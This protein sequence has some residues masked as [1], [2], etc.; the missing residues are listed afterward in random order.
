MRHLAILCVRNEAAFL[1]EW[2]AHHRAIGFDDF[3]VFSNDCQDGT[4]AMLD[5]LEAMGHLTH[6]RNDGPYDKGGIQFT[7]LKA[8]ARHDAVKRADWILP[9]DV[10]EFVNIHTGDH[11]L[12]ALHTALPEATA[13]TLTW[14]LFG[15]AGQVRFQDTPVTQTFTRC[16][17]S[18]MHWPW[19]AAMFKTLYAND[20]TYRKP[21]VHRP[22]DPDDSRLTE[23]RWFDSHGRALPPLFRKSRI[24]S[25]YG[26]ENYGLAQINHYPLGAAETYVLK[27]DRGRA[28]HDGDTLGLDYWVERN[29]NTDTD[30]TIAATAA[31]RDAELARLKADDRLA[32][33]HDAAVAWRKARFLALMQEE[34]YRAL[35]GRLLMTPPSQPLALQAARFLTNQANLGRQSAEK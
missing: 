23:S 8:S 3:L 10:D 12:A 34:P 31:A 13:I 11:T 19:R 33:L 16:A 5:R 24:F 28:V 14:R 29:F 17:P 7:A 15:C 26:R 18:I 25:T 22:R 27:A 9:L 35:F 1:L 4:D 32:E 2:L 6:V 20:G 21:G 30:T